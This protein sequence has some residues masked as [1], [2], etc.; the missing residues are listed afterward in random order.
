MILATIVRG[1]CQGGVPN[2]I[3]IGVGQSQCIVEMS[4]EKLC[5]IQQL[6]WIFS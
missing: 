3:S 6:K 4:W 2:K 1:E 5:Q